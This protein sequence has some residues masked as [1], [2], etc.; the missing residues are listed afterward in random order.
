MLKVCMLPLSTLTSAKVL[1]NT[2]AKGLD[3][4]CT[5]MSSS[6]MT[7]ASVQPHRL[8]V[9]QALAAE[10]TSDCL[11]LPFLHHV[12][13]L[14]N[15]SAACSMVCLYIEQTTVDLYQACLPCLKPAE[16]VSTICRQA[17]KPVVT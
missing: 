6:M 2:L 12:A 14:Q 7:G 16:M 8:T 9:T 17:A 3:V 11:M 1:Q 13:L 15:K 10:Q 4:T 5:V